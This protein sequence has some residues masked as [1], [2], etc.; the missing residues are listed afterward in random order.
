MQFIIYKNEEFLLLRK[1]IMCC[2]GF[3]QIPLNYQ[4]C[5]AVETLIVFWV[6]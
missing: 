4:K 6:L 1:Q 5:K 3:W 2:A